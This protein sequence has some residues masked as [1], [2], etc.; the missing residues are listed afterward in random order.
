M[1][2]KQVL[3]EE[4]ALGIINTGVEGP[5]DAVAKSTAYD[6]PSIGVSQWEGARADELLSN[7]EGGAKFMYRDYEDIVYSDEL[8]ELKSLLGSINGK[9]AQV[10][11]LA[12]DCLVY[13]DVLQTVP[14]F[15]DTKCLIYAGIWCPTNHNLVARFL[16][17]RA[18]SYDLRDLYTLY[19]VFREQYWIA[20]GVGERYQVG[21]SNRAINTYEYVN[22]LDLAT[23]WPKITEH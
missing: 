23:V 4:I 9:Q 22:E 19:N 20:A 13:V 1:N 21:Y 18:Y 5:F 15:D 10:D 8:D 3:A 16:T 12:R 7:I 11:L 17:H 6:Y 14:E 2:L